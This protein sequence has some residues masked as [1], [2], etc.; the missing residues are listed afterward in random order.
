[1]EH[2]ADVVKYVLVLLIVAHRVLVVLFKMSLKDEGTS[3]ASA[4]VHVE[5]N[6]AELVVDDEPRVVVRGDFEEPRESFES[7][8]EHGLI[9]VSEFCVEFVQCESHIRSF[10]EVYT[11]NIG[12][13]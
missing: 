4:D 8:I 1:M 2:L 9:G 11:I 3:F 6:L 5:S 13:S 12:N 10:V 7:S